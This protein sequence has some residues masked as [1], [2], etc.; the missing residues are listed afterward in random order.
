MSNDAY[1]TVLNQVQ[2]LSPEEQFQ[3]LEDLVVILRQR[4]ARKPQHS[5]LEFEGLGKEMWEGVNVEDYINEERDSWVNSNEKTATT[6]I[7][8]LLSI[9]RKSSR[10]QAIFAERV[11]DMHDDMAEIL[12]KAINLRH[13][14]QEPQTGKVMEEYIRQER[15]S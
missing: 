8:E 7:E 5:I 13:Q 4:T 9:L 15:D 3:L 10:E 11:K 2:R 6:R 14:N 1:D 12:A